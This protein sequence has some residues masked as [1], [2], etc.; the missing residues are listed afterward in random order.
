MA[1]RQYPGTL[2][3]I[4][5]LQ[6]IQLGSQVPDVMK[7]EAELEE[8]TKRLSEGDPL[9]DTQAGNFEAKYLKIETPSAVDTEKAVAHGIGIA[10]RAFRPVGVLAAAGY[11]FL[12]S[13]Y[14]TKAADSEN[15]YVAVASSLETN[16]TGFVAVW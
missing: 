12:S 1:T 6:D 11:R 7:I 14:A 9:N 3:R 8:L 5:T 15:I 4:L 13:L 2:G 10:P 16:K